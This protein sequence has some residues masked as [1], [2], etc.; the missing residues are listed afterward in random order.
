MTR[1]P[2]PQQAILDHLRRGVALTGPVMRPKA[3]RHGPHIP[4]PWGFAD[5]R[6]AH[7]GSVDALIRRGLIRASERYGRREAALA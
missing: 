3:D 1:L 5:G 7:K 2:D 6:R 4:F